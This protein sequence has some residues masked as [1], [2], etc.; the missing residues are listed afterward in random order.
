MAYRRDG[1]AR[2]QRLQ[3]S[4]YGNSY[5]RDCLP[6]PGEESSSCTDPRKPIYLVRE[7]SHS[8]KAEDAAFGPDRPSGKPFGTVQRRIRKVSFEDDAAIRYG[9]K[10][11]LAEIK[12]CVPPDNQPEIAGTPQGKCENQPDHYNTR[13][14]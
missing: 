13:C 7:N 6:F 1:R 8:Q 14:A 9:V 4:D 10:E 3:L 12:T 11:C 5:A 2:R